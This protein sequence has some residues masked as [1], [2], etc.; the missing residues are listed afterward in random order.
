MVSLK[1][2]TLFVSFEGL[3]GGIRHVL[4]GLGCGVGGVVTICSVC[5][6]TGVFS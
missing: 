2:M 1:F 4:E 6:S 5:V 3:G